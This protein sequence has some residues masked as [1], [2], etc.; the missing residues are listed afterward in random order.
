MVTMTRKE[1]TV[2]TTGFPQNATIDELV[3]EFYKVKEE[4]SLIGYHTTNKSKMLSER[5]HA[6]MWEIKK[7]L[8]Q[9]SKRNGDKIRKKLWD[10][11]GVMI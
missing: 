2:V 4:I 8:S 10:E 6:I 1:N 11:L 3:E 5:K 9:V 7:A